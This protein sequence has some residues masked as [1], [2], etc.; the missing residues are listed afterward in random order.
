[1][2]L[3]LNSVDKRRPESAAVIQAVRSA[4]LSC[5]VHTTRGREACLM[6]APTTPEGAPPGGGS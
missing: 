4:A 5:A 3:T 6:M 1:M 2:R